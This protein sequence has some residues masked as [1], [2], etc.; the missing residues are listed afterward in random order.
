MI[1]KSLMLRFSLFPLCFLLSL[2]SCGN[3]GERV[4]SSAP[5]TSSGDNTSLEESTNAETTEGPHIDFSDLT[6]TVMGDSITYGT[7][8]DVG[9][10]SPTSR[11]SNPFTSQLKEIFGLK[12]ASNMGK[13]GVS[14][15]AATYVNRTEAISLQC[16][17][18][19]AG[20]DII[21]IAGGT[22]DHGSDVPLGTEADTKNS[23]FYGGLYVLCSKLKQNHPNA[24]IIFLTPI[25]KNPKDVNGAGAT[26]EDYRIAIRKM[27]G[28]TFGFYVL[29][30]T[31]IAF[32]AADKSLCLDNCHPNQA[33]HDII[34]NY[35]A[36]EMLPI[37]EEFFRE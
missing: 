20:T 1:N 36:Q 17:A 34:A 35:L 8:T 30:G 10:S 33:G 9:D 2:S 21:L 22:N 32:D 14:I 25:D 18:I 12:R 29:D 13:N 7:F 23:S 24:C 4:S 6:L 15:S 26:L 19:E 27:A 28:D 31:D 11:V 5:S 3:K 16:V 37:L